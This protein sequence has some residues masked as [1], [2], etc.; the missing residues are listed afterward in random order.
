MKAHKR[1]IAI[2][3]C[4]FS[5]LIS[6]F[7]FIDLSYC[8][9]EWFKIYEQDFGDGH[10][11]DWHLDQGW[12]VILIDTNYVLSG[13]NHSWASFLR[14]QNWTSY[15]LKFKIII[16]KGNIHVNFRVSDSGRYF[17]PFNSENVN[18]S[19]EKP[20]GTF[21]DL[22]SH[23][24]SF[25]QGI[26]HTFE[27]VGD[28]SLIQI[29]VNGIQK[30]EYIDI[31]PLN[32]GS[33]AYE[34]LD[35]SHFLI[36]DIEVFISSD[37]ASAS[38]TGSVTDHIGD[39]IANISIG[40]G[41]Y[42]NILD[43]GN[44][45]FWTRTDSSGIF[46]FNIIP[47][48]YLVFL[49]SQ[50]TSDHFLPEAFMNI[51]SWH[52][53]SLS[54]PLQVVQGETIRGIDFKLLPGFNISGRLI[55]ENEQPVLGAQGVI[56]DDLQNIV[57]D[58]IFGTKTSYEDGTFQ[59]N[60]PLGTYHLGFKKEDASFRVV[61]DLDVT[62]HID[63]GDIVFKDFQTPLDNFNPHVYDPNYKLKSIVPGAPGSIFDLAAFSNRI[64]LA[65]SWGGIY[66]IKHDGY[67]ELISTIRAY[68][69]DA[70]ANGK[71]YAYDYGEKTFVQ[72]NSNGE[73]QYIRDPLPARMSA[74]VMTV[75]ST[76]NIWF[77]DNIEGKSELYKLT[78]EG[79]LLLISNNFPVIM[80]MDFN[81]EGQ[82][83]IV[84]FNRLYL[85]DTNNGNSRTI[86]SFPFGIG[87]QGFAIAPD[88]R[89]F[90]SRND[91][92][93]NDHIYEIP[94]T[95]SV[96]EFAKLPSGWIKGIDVM[97][98]GSL[99]ATMLRT[100]AIYLINT[101]GTWEILLTGNG[102]GSP[103]ALAFNLSGELLV[104]NDELEGIVRIDDGQGHFFVE[105][106][107]YI[108]PFGFMAFDKSGSFY[109]S[110]AA[111]GFE[112][113]LIK[114]APE[115]GQPAVVSS[116]LNDPSGLSF[117]TDGELCVAEYSSGEISIILKGGTIKKLVDGLQ[118]PQSMVINNENDIYVVCSS[119]NTTKA[120]WKIDS[121][122][123]KALL[124]DGFNF[125]NLALNSSGELFATTENNGQS[126]ILRI[127][128]DGSYELIA[129]GF[130]S[131]HGMAFDIHGNLYVSDSFDNSISRITGF[132]YGIIQGK[133][134]NTQNN[135][136]LA[137]ANISITS[138][139][140]LVL[141]TEL[142]TNEGG[143]YLID[144]TPRSYTIKASVQQYESLPKQIEVSAGD[145]LSLD[146]YMDVSTGVENKPA[147]TP[148]EFSLSQNYPNP[149]NPIT[150]INYGLP[151]VSNVEL[152]VY[153]LS[154]Q[155]VKTLLSKKQNAGTYQIQWD[156][157]NGE[158]VQVS[159]GMYL[160]HLRAGSFSKIRKMVLL[161]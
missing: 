160:Y 54:S 2:L 41:D 137:N 100:G 132:P 1:G 95:G 96:I 112:S 47:G 120:I 7:F 141:G 111:P 129:R 91:G 80:G 49:N 38:I 114:F 113:R 42:D 4:L 70:G 146:L 31:D 39:P 119:G 55:Y 85:I 59:F 66:E 121:L 35:D 69:I 110:E 133:V 155:K 118:L 20:W 19:K 153:N 25:A 23:S 30:F 11:D 89:M 97:Q 108:F 32:D 75:D 156:G 45:D 58:C 61:H 140:P 107:T 8:Q 143:S 6:A 157:T 74:D 16:I 17:I 14:G 145:T 46:N 52:N 144:V 87:W 62:S 131:A 37:A 76:G 88:D 99:I 50:S 106:I 115:G 78:K 26:W 102:M 28:D 134:I 117:S 148:K 147:S 152:T 64:F 138:N 81:S 116:A 93:D 29:Y 22:K 56:R 60:V 71:L 48:T 126:G 135:Q 9:T 15:K 109:F 84:D 151:R 103:E 128:P 139:Y 123:N 43:C 86:S 18:L 104:V 124:A 77:A 92:E 72:I 150:L 27:I 65:A 122:G 63:L 142:T 68:T 159:S 94:S 125:I 105:A 24:E 98:D 79:E 57:Y 83:Y 10:A 12:E 90:I 3:N 34:T 36:D 21:F 73:Y 5:F 130:R 149:F 161:R 82:L 13:Q 154:G 67:P 33:I 51:H 158:G 127:L 40:I 44:I 53:I 101:D 136:P